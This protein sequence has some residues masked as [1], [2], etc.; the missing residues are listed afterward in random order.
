MTTEHAD[1]AAAAAAVPCPE[2]R[3]AAPIGE[4]CRNLHN[5]A[6]LRHQPAHLARLRAAGVQL[7]PTDPR[8]RLRGD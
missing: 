1:Q 7:L 8:D 6:P 5:G 2:H 4:P 3:C